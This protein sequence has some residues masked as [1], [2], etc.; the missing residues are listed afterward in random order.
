MEGLLVTGGDPPPRERLDARYAGFA[1]I[2]AADSGLDTL[3]AWGLAPHIIVGDMDSVSSPALVERFPLARVLPARRDKDETDTELGIS[4]LAAAGADRI[5]LAGGG[6]GRLDHLLAIRAIF[7]RRGR[8]LRPC[9][10]H[11]ARDALYLV[12]EGRSLALEARPGSLVSVFPLAAGA[13]GMSS[14]G[15]KWRLDGLSWGPGDSGVSNVAE[16]G[17]FR[18]GAGA[19]DLLVV[20]PLA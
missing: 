10:W 7:E 8:G 9:E 2:C 18:V 1:L 5:V 12:E 3:A 6:G 20:L 14:S 13:R 17:A 11:T 4:A 19:G 16:E 15:L